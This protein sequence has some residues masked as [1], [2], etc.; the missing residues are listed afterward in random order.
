MYTSSDIKTLYGRF[1]GDATG[2]R[3]I[4]MENEAQE[5]RDRWPLLGMIDPR[6]VDLS[7]TE[8]A[9][10]LP[11]AGTADAG[12]LPGSVGAAPGSMP[13]G[14][15]SSPPARSQAALRRSAPLFARSLRRD[16]TRD[17]E[18]PTYTAPESSAFRFSPPPGA[19]ASPEEVV[20]ATQV[21]NEAVA[22]PRILGVPPTA[23]NTANLPP[24]VAAPAASAD[25]ATRP[26]VAPGG[27]P[28]RKLF[29]AVSA[30]T[31][32]QEQRAAST[33]PASVE[34]HL[35]RLFDRLREGGNATPVQGGSADP[36]TAPARPGFPRE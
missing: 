35:D 10:S 32:Q 5:A 14:G 28:L 22:V 18:K 33:T 16:L 2:Y 13:A 34:P 4:R 21:T 30:P 36:K 29:G 8:K 26:A 27:A 12:R 31:V 6:K 23:A 20:A 3:E 7:A 25:L 15:S 19:K 1:A 9:R 24:A 17:I 11:A